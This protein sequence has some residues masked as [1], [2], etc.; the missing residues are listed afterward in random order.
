LI[1]DAVG[2]PLL[3]LNPSHL[4]RRGLDNVHAEADRLF[5][6][7]E[8]CDQV[9]L[10]LDEFDELVREREVAGEFESR[11]L[12]TAMLPKLAALSRRRRLVYLLVTNH[13][14]QF[15]A[16]IRRP[17]RFD[18]ILPVMPPSTQEKLAKWPA[19]EDAVARLGDGAERLSRADAEVVV[20]DLTFDEAKE[21]ERRLDGKADRD[22]IARTI[23]GVGATA[24]VRQPLS[25]KDGNDWRARIAAEES[26]IRVRGY[27]F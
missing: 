5:G 21:L 24:T 13:I 1:H 15:D 10:L 19:L 20:G 12:T 22:E 17:G 8:L 11:F 25:D 6:K 14:E 7:L 2:W 4:T 26:R 18:V 3:P 27:E 23:E 9:I 16:A